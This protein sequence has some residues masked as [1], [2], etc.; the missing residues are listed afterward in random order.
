MATARVASGWQMEREANYTVVGAFVLLV[1]GMAAAFVYW[2]SDARGSKSYERHEIYF[3]G[4]VSGLTVG[5]TVRYLG[6]D[7]GRVVDIRLDQRAATR[8]QVIADIDQR[9][10]ISEKTVA[11]LSLLGVTGL[12]YIDLLGD[13]GKKRL[14]DPVASEQYPVIRSVRS[15]FDVLLSG[16]PEVMGRASEVAQR[17]N[18]LLSDDNLRAMSGLVSNLDRASRSLPETMREVDA[19]VR[20][21]RATTADL[22]AAAQALRG[23][24][25]GAAPAVAAAVQRLGAMADN[26]A[27]TSTR[28]DRCVAETADGVTEFTRNGLP[29]IERLVIE[30]RA[31]ADELRALSR[32]LRDEP[33]RLIYPPASRGV[34][35]P[36]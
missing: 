22:G 10:P 30:S 24:T 35:V 7:I 14:A 15:N 25:E 11:E 34:E 28:L 29:E 27:T 26:L 17:A 13:V 8:V 12:L 6:V 32:S 19:L 33:S 4:S 31:A 2:Y 23:T 1:V 5:S 18:Q 20:D 3:E 36:R 21:L 16:V 9:A